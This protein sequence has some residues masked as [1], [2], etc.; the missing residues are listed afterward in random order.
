MDYNNRDNHNEYEVLEIGKKRKKGLSF[1]K[2][3]ILAIIVSLVGGTAIGAGYNIVNYIIT[4]DLAGEKIDRDSSFDKSGEGG[5]IED[6]EKNFQKDSQLSTEEIVQKVGPSVVAITN[7]VQSR[8][9]FMNQVIQ[10]GAGSGVIFEI[11]NE[12]IM[13]MTN[14]HVVDK[15]HQLTVAFNNEDRADAKLIGA[16][17]DADLA[18]IQ[19]ERKDIPQGIEKSIKAIEFG[20]SDNLFVGERAIAIGNPLGYSGTVTSGIVSGLDRE[21]H[22]ADKNLK[23]IQ[24]DA[25][26][27]PGNSGGALVNG[28]GQLI[29]INT[30]KI[31]DSKVEGLGFA[32]PIN[33][34]KPII[35]ELLSQGYVSRPYLGIVA[36]DIDEEAAKIYKL[37]IG[38][39]IHDVMSGSA[40][41]KAGIRRGD[42]IIEID[43]DKIITME[44]LTKLISQKKVG[45][46]LT[47]TIVRNGKETKE[48]KATLLEKPNN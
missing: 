37:P 14:Q 13:I 22:L 38:I 35:Q 18:V 24:T 8:D 43:G 44:Q 7:R 21:L 33:Y 32:I 11:S 6:S 25:A 28:R 16:D 39:Y 19:I 27:N 36:G 4:G 12:G 2:I 3:I 26:I 40:A 9:I 29:G 48:L 34:A 15:A 1:T 31:A 45:D 20:D 23:L 17:P 5:I 46:E 10:E 30:I 42:V 47:I 41:H